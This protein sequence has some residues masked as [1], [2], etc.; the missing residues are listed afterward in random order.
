VPDPVEDVV[1]LTDPKAIRA[2]AHPARLIVIDAL[3]DQGLELTATQAAELAGT[4]PSA[5]SYHLRAL[6][7]FG[8]V[9]RAE[10]R[11]DA[12]ER[13]WVRAARDVRIRPPSPGTSRATTIATGAVLATAMDVARVRLLSALERG[14]GDGSA[15]LPLD[16]VAAYGHHSVVVTP[17]EARALLAAV[18]ELLEPLRAEVRTDPPED[19]GRMT[20]V[21][22][23][24]PDPDVTGLRPQKR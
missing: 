2:I 9:R 23:S 19:A 8:I 6:E 15:R 21:I 16:D 14:A 18:I 1:E 3:Y 24:I 11:D 5:M 13:P 4:S 17:D 10:P 20:F 12:R 22:A 7:K